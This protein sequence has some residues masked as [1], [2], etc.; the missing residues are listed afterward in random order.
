[1]ANVS[2]DGAA[3]RSRILFPPSV[4]LSSRTRSVAES[5][6]AAPILVRRDHRAK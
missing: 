3:R 6:G 2:V 4:V 5:A 1:M